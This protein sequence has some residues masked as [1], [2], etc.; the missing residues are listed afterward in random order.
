[1]EYVKREIIVI[2]WLK[3]KYSLLMNVHVLYIS[4]LKT[5]KKNSLCLI[6]GCRRYYVYNHESKEW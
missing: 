5:S 4:E 3:K 1:M 6:H 2:A